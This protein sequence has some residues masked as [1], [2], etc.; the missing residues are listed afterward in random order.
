MS[1]GLVPL[2]YN[3]RIRSSIFGQ[4]HVELGD[5]FDDTNMKITRFQPWLIALPLLVAC[6]SDQGLL[7][8]NPGLPAWL[9]EQIAADEAVIASDTTRLPNFGAWL[10]YR[11]EGAYY[12]EYDNPL[13]SLFR[14]PYSWEGT[15]PDIAQPPFTRYES[16]KCCEQYVWRGPRYTPLR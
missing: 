12:F 10:R 16:R 1:I 14:A 13:S 9:E 5:N 3:Q 6:Q 11:F 4:W 7:S 8:D 2:P 15:R